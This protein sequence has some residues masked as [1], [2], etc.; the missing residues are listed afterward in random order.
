MGQAIDAMQSLLQPLTWKASIS[1]VVVATLIVVLIGYLSSAGFLPINQTLKLGDGGVRFIR[2]WLKLAIAI[3]LMLPF[4]A[5][6]F[7]IKR[8]ELRKV[9]GFYLLVLVIQIIT[10]QTFSQRW[11]P[12]LVVPIGTLY[13]T[14][15]IWQLWQ[16]LQ[17]IRSKR[18]PL[19]RYKW[20]SGVLWVVFCFW[21]CNLVMLLTI[22]WASIL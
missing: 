13:T 20:L 10:E 18:R 17:L 16:G 21:V 2:G 4:V 14:F 6:V 22:V 8:P 7:E 9:F 1:F 5:F 11:M 3:G 15:R 19:P 12:S